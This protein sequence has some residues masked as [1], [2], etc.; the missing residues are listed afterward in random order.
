MNEKY[1]KYFINKQLIFS[2]DKSFKSKMRNQ[3]TKSSQKLDRLIITEYDNLSRKNRLII[4]LN[5]DLQ[6]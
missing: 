4:I 3:R 6:S 1:H 5:Q 2:I